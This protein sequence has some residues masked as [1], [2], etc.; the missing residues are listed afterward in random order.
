MRIR[1]VRVKGFRGIPHQ[2]TLNFSNSDS[3]TPLSCLLTGENGAGK[4]TFVDALEFCIS[5]RYPRFASE[6]KQHSLERLRNVV[7]PDQATEVE[8]TFADGSTFKRSVVEIDGAL[9]SV[10][11]APHPAFRGSG[12]ALHREEIISFLRSAPRARHG[13]FAEF[14]RNV[15]SVSAVPQEYSDAISHAESHRETCTIARNNAAR[16]LAKITRSNFGGLKT[17]LHDLASF[18]A[19]FAS[20]GYSRNQDTR[21][22]RITAQ[23]KEIYEQAAIVRKEIGRVRAASDEVAKARKAANNAP[24]FSLLGEVAQT[25][26][27]S[28]KRISPTAESVISVSLELSSESAEIALIAKLSNGVT[29]RAEGYFSEA[30]LD[31]LALLLFL[32]LM[33]FA[34]EHGQPKIMVLDDVL[35]SVDSAIRVKVA[36]YLLEEFKG[37]QFLVTF[38]DRLWKE[39]FSAVFAAKHQFVER[40]VHDWGFAT[41]P[42]IIE[43]RRDASDDLRGVVAADDPRLICGNA[44]YLLETLSDWMSKSLQTSVTRRYGDKYTLG[45]TWPSVAKKLREIGLKEEANRVNDYMWLR[46]IHGAH[47]NEWATGLSIVDARNFGDAVLELWDKVWCKTCRQTIGKHGNIFH[48]NCGIIRFP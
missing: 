11:R 35:Q 41:G 33:K 28:F 20:R 5:G 26:T 16:V 2:M 15:A 22:G 43:A 3:S 17:K 40:E 36:R 46:N 4:S 30:N 32:S 42:R 38:H 45:D 6:S 31:L 18:N 48:C 27:D 25:L 21:Q 13:V 34:S 19:W 29:V 24:L 12:L 44:G 23:R 1:S 14:M 37:W 7:S 10:P 9:D 39:Q 8:V 47:Y